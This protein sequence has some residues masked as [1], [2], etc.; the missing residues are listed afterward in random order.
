VSL[1]NINRS[2]FLKVRRRVYCY[3]GWEFQ[4]QWPL[5]PRYDIWYDMIW[6]DMMIYDMVWYD[7]VY[8]IWLMIWYDMIWWYDMMIWYDIYLT[9]IGLTPGGSSTVY[10]YTQT[11]HRQHNRHKQYIEQHSSLIR[12][13]A[14]RA[15]SL[16]GIPLH[17]PYNWGKS[18]EKPQSG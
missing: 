14:E 5:V 15:P 8:D 9:A 13:N 1:Y 10:I 3:R 7:T 18:T 11:I 17:L 6:Y 12:K 16:W 2:I 4:A